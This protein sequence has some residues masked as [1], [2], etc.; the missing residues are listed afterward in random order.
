MRPCEGRL[1]WLTDDCDEVKKPPANINPIYHLM[2]A[3]YTLFYKPS[4]GNPHDGT[5]KLHMRVV[6]R[7]NGNIFETWK[8]VAAALPEEAYILSDKAGVWPL[9]WYCK[10]PRKPNG[11][12]QTGRATFDKRPKQDKIS[13]KRARGIREPKAPRAAAAVSKAATRKAIMGK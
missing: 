8:A 9:D 11:T 4:G 13:K 7:R 6:N 10:I 1:L 2:P 5:L 3:H 12:Y